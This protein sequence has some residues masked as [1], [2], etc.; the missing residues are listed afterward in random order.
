M[1]NSIS[2][3]TRYYLRQLLKAQP[4]LQSKLAKCREQQEEYE[5][6]E[7]Y[8][9][10][11]RLRTEQVN[12]LEVLVRLHQKL[13]EVEPEQSAQLQEIETRILELLGIELPLSKGA[14]T[15][16]MT[17]FNGLAT[18]RQ[19]ASP[20]TT[21]EATTLG[22]YYRIFQKITSV[23][24]CYL[25]KMIVRNYWLA[26]RPPQSWLA[27]ISVEQ[28]YGSELP[29]KSKD[30]RLTSEQQKTLQGW[31]ERFIRQGCQVLPVLP[32]LLLD[33]GVPAS[34]LSNLGNGSDAHGRAAETA[35]AG[36][37]GGR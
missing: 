21:Q 36:S 22:E 13:K 5:C 4:A 12:E 33:A 35:P 3:L 16:M 17:F 37:E 15:Q 23:A 19:A 9:N 32:Q 34:L 7:S 30:Q 26:T 14:L 24:A 2:P 10:R 6:L 20:T 11:S 29:P 25:G 8:L 28:F 1:S 18:P 31:I 27:Q